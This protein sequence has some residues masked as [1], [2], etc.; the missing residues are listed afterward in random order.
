M[1]LICQYVSTQ[2]EHSPYLGDEPSGRDHPGSL[3]GIGSREVWRGEGD[4]TTAAAQDGLS[5]TSVGYIEDMRSTLLQGP[6]VT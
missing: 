6:D 4:G 1:S 2:V 5:Q 3:L